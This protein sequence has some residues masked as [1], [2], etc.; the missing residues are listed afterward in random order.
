[1]V[2]EVTVEVEEEALEVEE[3]EVRRSFLLNLGLSPFFDSR[4]WARRQRFLTSPSPFLSCL[5][6]APARSPSVRSRFLLS[7]LQV[8]VEDEVASSRATVLLRLSSVRSPTLLPTP[9]HTP[10]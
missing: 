5:L 2:E 8:E 7:F 6:A 3:E 4:L 9:S 10:N 1:M